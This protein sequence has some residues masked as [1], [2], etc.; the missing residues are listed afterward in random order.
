M[1]KAVSGDGETKGRL[2]EFLVADSESI[3][4]SHLLQHL[5]YLIY[6]THLYGL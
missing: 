5:Q 6:F 2:S 4:T 1:N 3:I